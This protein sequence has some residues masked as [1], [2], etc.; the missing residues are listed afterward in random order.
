MTQKNR[1]QGGQV[2]TTT[3]CKFKFDGKSY[4]AHSGDTLASALLANGVRLMGRSFK[5]HRPRG[6]LSAGS[7]EPNAL[8]ELRNGARQEPNTRATTIEMFDGLSANSQNR[9]GSL[10]F[11]LLA[12]NDRFSNF[13][14]AGFY[15]KTFMWPA[16]F[17]EKIYE[18]I[19]RKAAG[20]GS[21]SLQDDPD[22]YDKGFL[23]CDLLII[24][25]GPA[26]LMA[27]LTAGR[28]GANV[29]L[30][31]EDFRMGGRLNSET[32]SIDDAAGA[33]WAAATVAELANLPNVRL[34]S[35]TT[36]I[37]AFDH[38]IYGAVERVSDHLPTPE[39]GKPRQVLWRIYTK[40]TVL[41]AGAIERPIAF[42]NNDRP[43][44][45]LASSIRSYAN[46][47]AVAADQ[48]VAVFTNNDDGHRTAADLHAKGVKISAVVD[49]RADAPRSH[50][51]EVLHGEVVNTKG[52]LG[53][54]FAE[55]KLADGTMRVLEC[56]ALGMAGGW[57]PNVHMTCHQRGRPAW[58]EDIAAFVPGGALP[59]G[60]SVA[61]AA[62]GAFSTYAALTSGAAAAQK[63]L[64]LKGRLPATP[65]AEDAP[66]N[67]K[68][69][70]YV[71]GCSRAW[72]DLQNDVT[73]KDVKLS[74]QEGFRSVEHLKRY[75]TLGM[76]TDQGKT[77]NMGGLAIMAELAGKAIPEV[78]TTIFRPPYT[79]TAIGVLAGRHRGQ[80]FHPKRL[81]PSHRWAEEQGAV[82][83]EV[84]NW[85][86]A[87]W[88]PRAGETHWRETVD[89]EVLATRKSVGVCD[90]TTLGKVDVQGADAADFL[91]KIYCN[92]FAKLAVGK[93]RYGLM[94]R[95]DGIAMDDGTA[96]RLAEDHFV[97]TTTTANALPVYRHM[98]FV[99]QCLFPDM[100][101]QLIS[102]TEA[103]A[104]YA[105]A[106]P[107]S[108]K[109]LEKIVDQDISNDA[110]PFMACANI[111]ICGGLRARLFR[112]S[113]SGE[114]AYEIAVPSAYGDALMRRIIEV[115]AEFDVTPYGTEA[116]GVMRIEKGHA[117]G[118]ELNGTTTAQNLGM[119]RM[120]S[121]KKDSIGST[122]SEREGLN[123]EGDVRQVG[124]RPVNP[125]DPVPAGAHLMN[126]TG[127]VDA[128]HDQ[129][130]ATSACFSPNLGH[131]IALGFL[132]DGANRMG[133][134]MRLVSPLTGIDVQVEIVS[135]HFV[136]PEGE[137]LRA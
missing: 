117:A 9:L 47:F 96:A 88:F 50:D 13:L 26:G 112:I 17:W 46:R 44:I 78:G 70:W 71:E 38:G 125:D 131:A 29:I 95:E 16:A 107:N 60:M 69:F 99:R 122:L 8:V 31:D 68:P 81:T 2:D 93:T 128:G 121:K 61:G 5:Y 4:T 41:A 127:P 53:L 59:P 21:L 74:H 132:K 79:P 100:D 116:L 120:V 54:A 32:F 76:A 12:I 136:D 51:Y 82:F 15:Y 39:V 134:K 49:V 130:Y 124:I 28:A 55:V 33:D 73:V 72:L 97:V 91:N 77:S 113:F 133:E 75:T 92:G 67:L 22:V 20:L 126:A 43:G 25:A 27:A 24:G 64:G 34:M 118:N 90:V 102:T 115:G 3:T 6:V 48:R 84:G 101:V 89:R 106:G 11:D 45:M 104:Q 85:L 18:P 62:N 129:G 66:V 36:V 105:V 10:R 1:L 114:L 137:R 87:Q 108:R 58:N 35:R 42:E 110:F 111:T 86:R 83:V 63:A 65:Q 52:R 109:L 80:E 56:G 30:A 119:G 103:W 23:H 94:L 57:N 14:A 19:I 40:Q 37:G 98:E 7:E 135:A 123:A